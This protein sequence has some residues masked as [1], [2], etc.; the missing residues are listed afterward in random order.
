MQPWNSLITLF[1]F[2]N[3]KLFSL[4]D[5]SQDGKI[6]LAELNNLREEVSHRTRLFIHL[7]QQTASDITNTC[8]R[9]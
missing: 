7:R 4:M 1:P 9:D 3:N 2:V 5:R 8:I 6:T